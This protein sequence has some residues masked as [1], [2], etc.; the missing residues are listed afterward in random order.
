MSHPA[1]TN[2]TRPRPIS[3]INPKLDKGLAAYMAAAGAAGVSMLALSQPAEAKIVYTPA[4]VTIGPRT[5]FALDLNNDGV[6]DF[7]ISNWQYGHVSHLS[8]YHGASANQVMVKNL[9]YGSAPDLFAGVLIGPQRV[10]ENAGFMAQQSSVS[11]NSRND[12]P[13]DNVHNRYLGLKFSLNGETH[14]GWA[15]L[16]VTAKGS[17]V[18]TLT[19]YAYETVPNRPIMA[20]KTSGPVAAG[21]ID[22]EEMRAP[23]HRPA[24]VGMLARGADA[25]AIWRRDDE[26]AAPAA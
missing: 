3:Q 12:G 11:G 17:I 19:G 14:Y 2:S 13:W 9:A 16:T 8:I 7:V 5:G 26:V 10:F 15:R 25:L 23:S 1:S 4:H 18:A 20:G 22:P 24:T 6:V 21:A